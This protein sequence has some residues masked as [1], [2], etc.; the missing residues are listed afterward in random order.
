[1]HRVTALGLVLALSLSVAPALAQRAAHASSEYLGHVGRGL[2]AARA[3][4]R[5]GAMTAFQQAVQLQPERPEAVC[6][7]AELARL[8]DDLPRALEGYRACARA[9]REAN[10]Q[11]W[12]AR[13]LHGI[14]STLERIPDR[15]GEAR[16]AWQD[17]VAFADGAAAV[18]SP[19]VG[20]ARMAAIDAI[21]ELD[22]VSAEVRQR[23]EARAA[24]AA[25]PAQ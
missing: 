4:D 9:A 11:R 6:H 17:Y 2:V 22:R 23:A 15:L 24:E 7:I 20:R 1:M 5:V 10:E 13:G 12:I 25:Q 16:T 21:L 3:G 18:A 14:A 19:A 8:N